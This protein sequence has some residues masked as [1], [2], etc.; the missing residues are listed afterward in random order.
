METLKTAPG[1]NILHAGKSKTHILIID[2]EGPIRQVL[3]ESLKDEGYV[4][5]TAPDG[6]AGLMALKNE[7]PDICFLDIWMPKLDGIEVLK[8]A[9]PLY[10]DTN[11]IM[12]S[13]HGTIETAVQATKLGAWD[14]VEKPLSLDKISLVIEN[15]LKFKN[16]KLEKLALLNKLRNS[17]ALV[18]ESK[19]LQSVREQIALFSKE[20]FPI[21]ISGETGTGRELVCQNI[22]YMSARASRSM[23]EINC[24]TL[25]QEL[26]EI[27]MFGIEKGSLP[28][29]DKT[30]KGKLE[31]VDEGTLII[32]QIEEMPAVLQT[33]LAQFIQTKS[34]SRVGGNEF[35][36]AYPR[37]L[38]TTA[39]DQHQFENSERIHPELKK[40]VEKN[41]VFV[42]PLRERKEDILPLIFHFSDIIAKQ[43]AMF[44]KTI[45]E[46]GLKVLQ[47]HSW[48]GNIRELKNYIERVYILTPSD[49]VDVHDLRFAG[50]VDKKES[51]SSSPSDDL[52]EMSTFREARA[53]FEKEY[54][55]KKIQEN[56][57]NISKTA[58]AI[59]L[60]R[61]YLHRKIKSYGI[62]AV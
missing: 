9:A 56:G 17:I 49:Y 38:L 11:F 62:E 29:I 40:I 20:N 13:G 23:T 43:M 33:K 27:E 57:G 53:E 51:K 19:A 28:G 12:I 5:T 58:E 18:G 36:T 7:K 22:H 10:P 48:P 25:P 55:I 2:D 15:V 3:S 44:R 6:E 4:V 32:E 26:I 16:E 24:S 60:E 45:S 42:P 31:L 41:I 47:K 1:I 35:L 37:I 34:F 14:F 8:K 30:R 54:L 61:S 50:L 46:Q 52:A 39:Y 21:L 59:G